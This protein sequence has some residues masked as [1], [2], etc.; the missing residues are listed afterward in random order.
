MHD[1]LEY[2]RQEPVHRRWHHDQM[3]FGLMYAFSE[4]FILPLSHDE[5]VHGKGSLLSRIP[6][7]AW[8]QFATL[9]AYYAVMWAQPGKKLL[10][11][12]QEFAQ[13]PEWNF[14][15]GLEWPLL[16]VSWHRGTQTLVRDCNRTYRE[17]RALHD[18]D[19]SADGF[20]WIVVDDAA[21]S[22]FGWL[23]FG[24]GAPPVAVIANFT[25]VP[26]EG[27]RIG[28][29]APGRWREILNTDA[30]AY[31]GSGCGNAGGIDARPGEWNGFPCSAALTVPPLGTL[32]LV[33]EGGA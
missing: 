12:G 14:A 9:R 29:P 28:L 21:S 4:N 25:P 8:Q 6:G 26:R 33:H 22:V 23:R 1:T 32:W 15:A 11:M 24:D 30:A 3:T 7:D 2:L 18:R 31:G 5:V 17:H 27:Y 10:F 16:D 13:G 20:R 19:C